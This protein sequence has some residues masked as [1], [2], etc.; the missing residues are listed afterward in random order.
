MMAKKSRSESTSIFTA[1]APCAFIRLYDDGRTSPYHKAEPSRTELNEQEWNVSWCIN[2]YSQAYRV[3]DVRGNQL[4]T[5]ASALLE[6]S[7]GAF[8]SG[9]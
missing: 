7:L 5:T 9:K 4:T 3:L 6:R 2:S 8:F 1:A